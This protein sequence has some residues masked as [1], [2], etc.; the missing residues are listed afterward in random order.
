[1]PGHGF[2]S[3]EIGSRVARDRVH[4]VFE[5]ELRE[6]R[7]LHVE[8]ADGIQR[9]IDAPRL[10]CDGLGMGL[11]RPLV[12]GVD[13]G[14]FN[15]AAVGGDVVGHGVEEDDHATRSMPSRKQRSRNGRA[16]ARNSSG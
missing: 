12:E 11:D 4:E 15:D 16:C 13:L 1:M 2:R 14:D 8:D 3:D 5:G 6:G 10:R 7:A 9:D